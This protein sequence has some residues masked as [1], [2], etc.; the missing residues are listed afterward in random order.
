MLATFQGVVER[1]QIRWVGIAPPDGAKVVVVA[2]E[3]PPLE[4][5][6]KR[7]ASIPLEE[8]QR[9]FDEFDRL[10]EQG[11]QPEVDIG[12]VSDAELVALVHQTRQE[13][14]EESDRAAGR[15]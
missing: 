4:E 10:A 1:G 7:L 3:W 9:A 12:T 11:I 14:R 8:R 6:L 5:Q 13:R 15:H 2:Q